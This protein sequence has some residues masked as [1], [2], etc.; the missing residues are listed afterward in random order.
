MF[1]QMVLLIFF[2]SSQ[3][4]ELHIAGCCQILF[5]QIVVDRQ[6]WRGANANCDLADIIETYL[7]MDGRIGHGLSKCLQSVLSDFFV[8]LEGLSD[9]D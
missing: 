2:R 6:L 4:I 1:I 5:S 7:I 3:S 8:L 9:A